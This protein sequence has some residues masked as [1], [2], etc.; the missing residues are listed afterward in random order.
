[1]NCLYILL[2]ASEFCKMSQSLT[3]KIKVNDKEKD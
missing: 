2:K 3:A 1:M